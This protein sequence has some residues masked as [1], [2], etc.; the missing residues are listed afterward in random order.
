MYVS[1]PPLGKCDYQDVDV[2]RGEG[3]EMG[4]YRFSK[5]SS[6]LRIIVG[7]LGIWREVLGIDGGDFPIGDIGEASIQL[8]WIGREIRINV[9]LFLGLLVRIKSRARH[10]LGDWGLLCDWEC[11]GPEEVWMTKLAAEEEG[12]CAPCGEQHCRGCANAET[13]LAG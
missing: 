7:D 13:Q 5:I 9:D 2:R 1:A 8:F 10:L 3:E 11:G 12:G 4:S 6:V